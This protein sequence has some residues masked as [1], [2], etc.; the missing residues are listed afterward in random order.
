MLNG[1]I[2]VESVPDKIT[3]FT[4]RLPKILVTE[5]VEK[6]ST[7]SPESHHKKPRKPVITKTA[8][9][10]RYIF[11]EDRQTVTVIDDDP[12]ML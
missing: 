5:S 3:T 8:S 2:D 9:V 1:V 11:K 10:N 7:K 12:E 6:S 4:I